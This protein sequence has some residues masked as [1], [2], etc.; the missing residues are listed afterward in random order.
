MRQQRYVRV[1]SAALAAASVAVMSA[2][3]V[4]GGATGGSETTSAMSAPASV[5]ISTT[6]ADHGWDTPA[7]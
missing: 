5:R 1:V 2:L 4:A 7:P 3:L 6:P